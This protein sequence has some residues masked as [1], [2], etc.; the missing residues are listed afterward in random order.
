MIFAK[1]GWNWSNGSGE[2]YEKVK[3][4]WTDGQ[5]AIRKAPLTFQL[6]WT[7]KNNNK[8]HFQYKTNM[9]MP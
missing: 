8:K 4:L 2:E 1:L 6:S 9:A 7:K 3:S 5:H